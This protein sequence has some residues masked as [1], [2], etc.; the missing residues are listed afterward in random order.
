MCDDI[1]SYKI[2][3]TPRLI[4]TRVNEAQKKDLDSSQH[5]NWLIAVRDELFFVEN[6]FLIDKTT[7]SN[8][9]SCVGTVRMAPTPRML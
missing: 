3:L 4:G 2:N 9:K 7:K 8:A 5:F 6:M 1:R